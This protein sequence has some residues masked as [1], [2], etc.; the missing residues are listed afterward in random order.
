MEKPEIA[1]IAFVAPVGSQ[2]TKIIDFTEKR[3]QI[4][5]CEVRRFEIS[6]HFE[7]WLLADN[8][9]A[10]I[11]ILERLRNTRSN[12]IEN[13]QAKMDAGDHLCIQNSTDHLAH[14]TAEKIKNE[15]AQCDGAKPIAYLLRQLKRP[16]ELNYLK[17][18]FGDGLFTIGVYGARD[19]RI[20]HLARDTKSSSD[21][22]EGVINR[23][24]GVTNPSKY[25]QGIHKLFQS[26]DAF[27]DSF[28]NNERWEAS[29]DRIIQL[30]MGNPFV[31]PFAYEHAMFSA[32]AAS[33]QSLDL[34]RQVGAVITDNEFNLL[35]SGFNEVPKA[36]GGQYQGNDDEQI[37][38]H[39][40]EDGRD[41][42]RREDSNRRAILNIVK[43]LRN[44]LDKT[45]PTD[46]D[47]A[48]WL[49][50]HPDCQLMDY[51]GRWFLGSLLEPF[52]IGQS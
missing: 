52:K 25:G 39:G 51:R 20:E 16:D 33:L 14:L 10:A 23:D 46:A 6:S 48:K 30:L 49:D 5:G 35:S 38:F 15:L 18:E 34:S 9:P 27:V 21:I 3:L 7:E 24:E 28:T 13:I 22:A 8:R 41:V 17:K 42:K 31:A 4:Y 43:Q 37:L 29:T 2:L 26:V 40:Q 36:F 12:S 1:V 47:A 19:F 44:G 45:E 32:F 50:E 11:S